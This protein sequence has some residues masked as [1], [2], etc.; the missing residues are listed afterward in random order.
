[1][2]MIDRKGHTA[3]EQ[4]TKRLNALGGVQAS[5]CFGISRWFI[6]I[7]FLTGGAWAISAMQTLVFAYLLQAI[8]RDLPMD[9]AQKALVNGSVMIGAFLGSFIF[10]N[11]ADTYGRKQMLL[12]AFTLGTVGCALCA[13]SPNIEVLAVC[14][15]IAGFGL[16]GEQPIMSSLVLELSPERVRGRMLVYMDAFWAVGSILA[17][18]LA[19]ELEPLIGWR[20]VSALNAFFLLYAV[21]IHRYIPESPKW[22][23]T[24]GRYEDAVKVMR[25]I[26]AS[27]DIFLDAE[28]DDAILSGGARAS[29]HQQ[30]RRITMG[31]ETHRTESRGTSEPTFHTTRQS[32]LRVLVD[33]FRLLFRYPYFSRTL[34]LWVVCTGMSLTYYGIDI[35]FFDQ[36]KHTLS[37]VIDT[38][39]VIYSAAVAQIPGY[40]LAADLVERLGR[41]KTIM[42]FLFGACLA[43]LV[44]AY[45]TPTTLTLL[46]AGCF[47]GFFFMGA[48]GALYPYVPEHYPIT[49]R[50][51]GSAYAWGVSRIGGFLGPYLVIWMLEQWAFT[52]AEV[53]WALCGVLFLVI[54]ALFFFGVETAGQQ[55]DD[56]ADR[57]RPRGFTMR[58]PVESALQDSLPSYSILEE[59]GYRPSRLSISAL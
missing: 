9:T 34:V 19:Y 24:M 49:I 48:W 30:L 52:V 22:L 26:E 23:A 13:L 44:G 51:M 57:P 18:V 42:A 4:I 1:M 20:W 12:T 29:P 54:F 32:F 8:Q 31:T 27:C 35:Y 16:G 40:L 6:T 2:A 10:G 15:F 47:R 56:T 36:L 50:V 38:N 28:A 11:L 58:A 17:L 7:L 5:S 33:R 43:S 59:K 25:I 53:V 14:R 39:L 21:L 55:I 41:R 3:G 46:L 45:V 37:G